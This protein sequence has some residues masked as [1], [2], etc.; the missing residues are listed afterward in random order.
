MNFRIFNFHL[1][2][3]LSQ[4]LLGV[5]RAPKTQILSHD[6]F[7]IDSARL[8]GSTGSLNVRATRGPFFPGFCSDPW[9]FHTLFGESTHAG[10]KCFMNINRDKR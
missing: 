4:R 5:Q 10:V 3:D 1:Q 2:M 7:C 6:E 9:Y 8:E